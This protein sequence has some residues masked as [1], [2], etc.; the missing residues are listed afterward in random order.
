MIKI[1]PM[2]TYNIEQYTQKIKPKVVINKITK[3]QVHDKEKIINKRRTKNKEKITEIDEFIKEAN[4]FL[5]TRIKNDLEQLISGDMKTILNI[6]DQYAETFEKLI[7]KRGVKLEFSFEQKIMNYLLRDIFNYGEIISKGN[8]AYEI[9]SILNVNVCPYCNREY[10]NTIM[11]GKNKVIR[12][13][14][15][16]YYSKSEYPI[17]AL[18]LYNLIPYCKICNQKKREKS[19]HYDINMYPFEEGVE[20][21]KVFTY[22]LPDYKIKIQK[23]DMEDKYGRF[24]KNARI[25]NIEEIYDGAHRNVV[26]N[27][28]QKHKSMNEKIIDVYNQRLGTTIS[29]DENVLKFILGYTSKEEIKNVS[30]SKLKNDIIDTLFDENI[31]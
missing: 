15:D 28:I 27:I 12:P 20:D 29:Q 8:M 17:F 11:K 18:S 22:E 3:K 1:N 7:P 30:L 25:L 2:N 19:F 10:T 24:L 31:S 16:H 21:K 13:D 5:N 23:E 4:T 9:M 14:F 6:Y 26:K